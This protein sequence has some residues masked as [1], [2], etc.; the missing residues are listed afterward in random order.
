MARD[1]ERQN[2]QPEER[3]G[4]GRNTRRGRSGYGSDS[5]RP[6]LRAQLAERALMRPTFPPPED[7]GKPQAN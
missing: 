3:R 4:A 6:H 2:D 5:V 1:N 7:D